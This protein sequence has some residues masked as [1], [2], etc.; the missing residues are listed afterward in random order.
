[1]CGCEVYPIRTSLIRIKVICI[2]TRSDVDTPYV[3][4]VTAI[5]HI[6][7]FQLCSPV[8]FAHKSTTICPCAQL[9]PVLFIGLEKL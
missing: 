3:E 2:G 5:G 8:I 6:I 4:A 7:Y 1:M 9:I